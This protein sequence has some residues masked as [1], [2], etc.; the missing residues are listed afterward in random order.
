MQSRPSPIKIVLV[1][2]VGFVA[3]ST[4]ALFVRLGYAAGEGLSDVGLGLM[5]ATLRLCFASLLLIPIWYRTRN[6]EAPRSGAWLY[7]I[8]A[9]MFLAIHFGSWVPAF[10]FTTIAAST[11]IASTA[12][13][14]VALM[15]W[16]FRGEIPSR[17][18]I[19][20][21]VVAISGAV[22]LTVGDAGGDGAG[23]NPLLGNVLAL[24]AALAFS[25]SFLM[26]QEAQRR[27]FGTS[28][29]VAI[30]Y[31]VGAL[32]LVGVPFI[33]GPHYGELP[34][35]VVFYGLLLALVPQ[36]IGHTSFNWAVK[37]VTPTLVTLV[38]LMEPIGATILGIIFFQ[39]IPGWIVL[40]GALI[41]LGGVA[42]AV[43]GQDRNPSPEPDPAV[44]ESET[45]ER[46]D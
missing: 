46:A 40:F 11:T 35:M 36:L 20:G 19:A 17:L 3:A 22:V 5:M 28:R 2:A 9:G 15:L 44:L 21:I 43:Y 12:P 16:F 31:A 41:L 39:E 37:W 25:G 26:G 42:L 18:T 24:S 45:K 7:A 13:I 1:L 6:D 14:W 30:A 29:Y 32:S 10:A 38:I 33:V 23:S 27:G 8:G 4:A 34:G